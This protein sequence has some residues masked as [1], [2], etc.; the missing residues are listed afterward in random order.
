MVSWYSYDSN[1]QLMHVTDSVLHFSNS[2]SINQTFYDYDT[3]GRLVKTRYYK[4]EHKNP[5]YV[6]EYRYEPFEVVTTQKNDS[7]TIFKNT[8]EFD[9]DFYVK[10][11]FGY[12]LEPKLK[13]GISV[14]S[15]DSSTYQYKDYND[16][17]RFENEKIIINTFDSTGKILTSDVK[18]TFRNGIKEQ[19]LWYK[20]YSNGL[21][22]N[23]KGYVPRYF[24]YDFFK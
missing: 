22:K 24:K 8:K 21:F 11:S 4:G 5:Y 18:L 14:I 2:T 23:I 3:L 16:L 19:K 12:I 9:R 13:R 17:Q 10:K 15:G 20:Y 7:I 6:K 1:R